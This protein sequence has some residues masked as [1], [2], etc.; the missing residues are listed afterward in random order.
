MTSEAGHI[1]TVARQAVR[2]MVGAHVEVSVAADRAAAG[3]LAGGGR[4][5]TG[6][7]VG[8]WVSVELTGPDGAPHRGNRM[9]S[10]KAEASAW[11]TDEIVHAARRAADRILDKNPSWRRTST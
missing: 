7:A 4:P 5:R 1:Q 10:A 11:G 9:D 2:S 8:A 3:R 6:G